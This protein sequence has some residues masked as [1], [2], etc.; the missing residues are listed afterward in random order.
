MAMISLGDLS[1]SFILRRH[2]AD[3][4]AAVTRLST[5]VTTGQVSDAGKHLSGDLSGLTGI[6]S[7]LARLGAYSRAASDAAFF[8]GAMQNA[9][10]AVQDITSDLVPTLLSVTSAGNTQSVLTVAREAQQA[11]EA[12]VGLYNTRLGDRAL[13]SGDETAT[14]PLPPADQLF[15]QME[16]AIAGALTVQDMETALDTWFAAPTGFLA[17]G[18]QGGGALAALPVGPGQTAQID[19]TAADPAIRETLKG[20]GMVA[21]LARGLFTGSPA[22]QAAVVLRSGEVLAAGQNSRALLAGRLGTAEG[23]I[24]GARVRNENERSALQI[25]RTGL[26]SVDPFDA[27][28]NLQEKQGQLE[29]LY[30]LT[31]R[32]SRLNLV[33]F[34]R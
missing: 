27:A 25:A 26:L 3:L 14:T 28:A 18:Y 11:F 34:L 19:I 9:L 1:Q 29:M 33:D 12:A 8:S 32:L 21:L 5:E 4:K 15:Q 24:E 6:D 31:A 17:A 23:Q 30:T 7:A 2:N 16:T 20:L 22:E 13:F 10:S